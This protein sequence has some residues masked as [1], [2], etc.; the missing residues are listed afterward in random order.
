MLKKVVL[1]APF[2]PIRLTI[3]PR[4]IVK[5][6]LLTAIRP[7]KPFRNPTTSIRSAIYP[8]SSTRHVV[9]GFVVDAFVELGR[10]SR[11]RNP[12]LGPE[13]HHHAQDDPEDPEPPELVLGNRERKMDRVQGEEQDR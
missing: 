8:P 10:A 1:P 4:G 2:G 13:E 3:V 6:T 11:A 12:A 5:S 7:P 9:E